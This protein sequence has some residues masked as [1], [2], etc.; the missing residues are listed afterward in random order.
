MY[1][2]RIACCPLVS[3]W[4]TLSM[5]RRDRQSDGQTDGRQTV[6]LRFPLDAASVII[7][8]LKMTNVYRDRRARNYDSWC[9]ALQLRSSR[10]KNYCARLKNYAVR[11]LLARLWM[12]ISSSSSNFHTQVSRTLVH[13]CA[14]FASKRIEVWSWNEFVCRMLASTCAM[15]RTR[16]LSTRLRRN[17]LFT[18]RLRCLHLSAVHSIHFIR[19]HRLHAVHICGLLLHVLHVAWSVCLSVCWAHG[20]TVQKRLNRSRCRMGRWRICEWVQGIMW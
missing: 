20:W 11:V 19:P 15:P 10:G 5:L 7:L 3:K 8:K 4:V 2:K 17:S 9:R 12:F 18:V 16:S 14:G 1:A 13:F 6:K